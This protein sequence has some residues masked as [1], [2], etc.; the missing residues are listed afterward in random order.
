MKEKLKVIKQNF[1]KVTIANTSLFIYVKIG[2]KQTKPL[3]NFP[4]TTKQ[5]QIW[6]WM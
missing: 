3:L 2:E 6:I 1:I 4:A 5:S